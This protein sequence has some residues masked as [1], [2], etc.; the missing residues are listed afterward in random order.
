M[1]D[2]GSPKDDQQAGAF[3]RARQWPFHPCMDE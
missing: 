1:H 3:M 2:P